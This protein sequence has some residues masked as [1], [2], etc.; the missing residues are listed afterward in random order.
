MSSEMSGR[1]AK[2]NSILWLHTSYRIGAVVDA[3]AALPM[4]FP[5]IFAAMNQ[6]SDFNP[7]VAYQFAMGM[8]AALML[9]WTGLLIWADRK[10]VE[11]KGVLL[12][13]VFVILGLAANEIWAVSSQFLSFGAVAPIGALQAVLVILFSLSYMQAKEN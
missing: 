6:L 9:G 10:P 3:I 8:G 7:G 5:G 1:R 11:R 12:L 2:S 4:L 13:T